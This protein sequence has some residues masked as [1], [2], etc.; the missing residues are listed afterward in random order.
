MIFLYFTELS[1]CRKC[2]SYTPQS[3]LELLKH[4]QKCPS[5]K[6]DNES[7]KFVCFTCDYH[8]FFRRN[9]QRHLRIHTGA[10]PY[11]CSF[12]LYETAYSSHVTR[13]MKVR[14]SDLYGH[15]IDT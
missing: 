12:C 8:T 4:C 5:M 2:N 3:E 1:F 10:K 9:M 6:R 7:Y 11:K 14:H 13:H 15:R